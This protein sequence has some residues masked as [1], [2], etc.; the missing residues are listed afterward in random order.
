VLVLIPSVLGEVNNLLTTNQNP[1]TN[2]V[3]DLTQGTVVGLINGV[4]SALK[5]FA[6]S[7]FLL[8][9]ISVK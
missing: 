2:I 6:V 9:V 5:G 3:A 4:V 1:V 7:S 8:H